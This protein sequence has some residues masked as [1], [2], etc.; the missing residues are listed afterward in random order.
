MRPARQVASRIGHIDGPDFST[1]NLL[2]VM[3]MLREA[4]D[5]PYGRLRAQPLQQAMAPPSPGG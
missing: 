5:D 4:A 1:D 3:L 2:N